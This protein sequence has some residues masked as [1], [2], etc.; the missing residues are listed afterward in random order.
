M[1][2]KNYLFSV[3]WKRVNAN[4][5]SV[6]QACKGMNHCIPVILALPQCT[7][8][9]G[10]GENSEALRGVKQSIFLFPLLSPDRN[11]IFCKTVITALY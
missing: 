11:N 10:L 3:L 7:L 1:G 9:D 5:I 2:G 8:S 6:M 4:V